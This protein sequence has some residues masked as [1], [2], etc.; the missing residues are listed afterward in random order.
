[1]D[2]IRPIPGI[3][4]FAPALRTERDLDQAVAALRRLAA[5]DPR[6]G[7]YRIEARRADKTFPQNSMEL[8]RILGAAVGEETGRPV[9]LENPETTFGVQVTPEAFLLHAERHEGVG[10]LPVGTAGR[11]LA[12]VS[13]GF[14]SP[15]AAWRMMRRGAHCILVHFRSR[16]VGGDT[17]SIEK[18]EDLAE[19]LVRTQGHLTCLIVPFGDLQQEIVANVPA[20]WRMI[21]Y[22]RT[23]FRVAEVLRERHRALGFVTGD[24]LAQVASQTLENIGVIWSIARRPVFAPLAGDDKADIIDQ[25][26]RLGTFE[27]SSRPHTD[28]CSFM[29]A[30]HPCTHARLEDVERYEADCDFETLV[31]AAADAVEVRSWT[32]DRTG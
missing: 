27:I 28:C 17:S 20:E 11:L 21:V 10:G 9:D 22:R 1:M 4:W 30:P 5:E 32:R 31:P 16:V 2:R 25:A 8:N 13:G 15:V 29:V 6:I 14:D 24:A 19:V 12:L 18:V 23:M 7:P 26:R 3:A